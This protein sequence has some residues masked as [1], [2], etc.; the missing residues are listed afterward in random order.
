MATCA[1]LPCLA[2]CMHASVFGSFIQLTS[3][4]PARFAA[5]GMNHAC[6]NRTDTRTLQHTQLAV[7]DIHVVPHELQSH[8]SSHWPLQMAGRREHP[9]AP[10][11]HR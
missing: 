7:N 8:R 11:W 5:A 2:P 4:Y 3:K 6:G 10:L 9:K 1:L